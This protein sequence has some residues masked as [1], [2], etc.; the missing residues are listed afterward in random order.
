MP[1]RNTRK[2]PFTDKGHSIMN[3]YTAERLAALTTRHEEERKRIEREGQ[4]LNTLPED[5][6]A[7]RPS[8]HIHR[9]WDEVASLKFETTRYESLRKGEPDITAATLRRLAEVFPPIQPARHKDHSTRMC[10]LAYAEGL[11]DKAEAEDREP[12][13]IDTLAPMW[14][15]FD[16]ASFTTQATFHWLTKVDGFGIVRIDVGFPLHSPIVRAF[17]FVEVKRTGNGW[18]SAADGPSRVVSTELRVAKGVVC[19]ASTKALITRYGSGS[20]TEPGRCLLMWDTC[21]LRMDEDHEGIPTIGDMLDAA[22]V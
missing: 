1:A 13:T 22:G 19:I 16:A 12:G 21:G 20:P 5:I 11:E 17:G 4:L 7:Y 3:T 18:N 9:L 14:V 8:V 2:Q 15:E 6:A 10:S